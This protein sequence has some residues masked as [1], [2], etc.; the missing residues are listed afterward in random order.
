[1]ILKKAID[2]KNGALNL[3]FTKSARAG[4]KHLLTN[5]NIKAPYK[6]LLPAYI[7][8]TEREGSGVFDPIRATNTPY[9][10][11][12][13][14]KELGFDIKDFEK[15][16]AVGDIKLVLVI[17]YFGFCQT[18]MPEIKK[19]CQKYQVQ[20]VE[21]CAHAYNLFV[22]GC[23]LGR[24]GDFSFYALHK[25]FPVP[26]GGI[27][28]VNN[29]QSL[30][31]L[32]IADKCSEQVLLQILKTNTAYLAEKRRANYKY[33]YKQLKNIAGITVL[34]ELPDHI[35]PHNLPILIHDGLREALYFKLL[36]RNIPTIALY[37][38][39]VD[40]I[41]IDRYPKSYELAKSILNLPIHQD[42]SKKDLDLL[43]RALTTCLNTLKSIEAINY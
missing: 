19:I 14:N 41:S 28:S 31:D 35:I 29:Q 25:F 40:V 15:R 38:Q 26:S 32:A 9:D 17:H 22:E 11:Y 34:Y 23:D 39:M 27:L 43:V 7:G 5:L 6:V 1:M 13:I 10:F 30:T 20:L 2:E 42:I 36:E 18:D 33:L 24:Y 8:Y 16:V 3:H 12:S 37:Y 21:D 4:W